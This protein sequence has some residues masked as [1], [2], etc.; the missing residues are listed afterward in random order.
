MI[1]VDSNVPIRAGCRARGPRHGDS[2]GVDPAAASGEETIDSCQPVREPL[3]EPV[4]HILELYNCVSRYTA[5]RVAGSTHHVRA[6]SP[7]T[8][9]HYV[10]EDE[11]GFYCIF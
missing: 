8:L 7:T 5:K 10:P 2:Q 6:R 1:D 3:L 11:R 9:D 4:M